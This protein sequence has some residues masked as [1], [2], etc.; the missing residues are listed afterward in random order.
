MVGSLSA[1]Q[2]IYLAGN[3]GNIWTRGKGVN[4]GNIQVGKGVNIGTIPSGKDINMVN[5]CCS[6]IT[7]TGC[8]W[9]CSPYRVPYSDCNQ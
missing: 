9:L 6:I 1:S 4:I 5:I 8:L 3:K 2:G 7:L